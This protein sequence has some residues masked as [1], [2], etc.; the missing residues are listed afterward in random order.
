LALKGER[1]HSLMFDRKQSSMRH[2]IS[3]EV[4]IRHLRCPFSDSLGNTRAEISEVHED[5]GEV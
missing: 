3:K 4:R 2:L 1:V 5:S